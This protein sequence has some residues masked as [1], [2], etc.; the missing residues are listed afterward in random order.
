MTK[1]DDQE[2][3]WKTMGI[4]KDISHSK[5]L[6]LIRHLVSQGVTHEGLLAMNATESEISEALK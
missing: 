1:I 6:W 3:K 4:A 5:R 2:S